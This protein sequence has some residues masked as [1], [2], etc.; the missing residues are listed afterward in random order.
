MPGQHPPCSCRRPAC[1]SGVR[2]A[3]KGALA[4]SPQEGCLQL[5]GPRAAA[6]RQACGCRCHLAASHAVRSPRYIRAATGCTCV[7][8]HS[9]TGPGPKNSVDPC[10]P[11]PVTELQ[12]LF[13][14]NV[15]KYSLSQSLHLAWAV[16]CIHT[17]LSPSAIP[18]H[19][20]PGA[21]SPSP[22]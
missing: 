11:P 3:L 10:Q 16:T 20:C 15:T 14:P 13:L 19:S 4:S 12:L 2:E 17:P 5:W 21:L 8:G 6:I 1:S 7:I 9:H 22:S 18:S